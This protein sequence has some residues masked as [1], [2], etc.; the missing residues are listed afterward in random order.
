M[1]TYTLL[2]ISAL[3]FT[4]CGKS[5]DSAAPTPAPEA[6]K[7]EA[8]EAA[9]PEAAKPE[10]KPEAKKAEAAKPAA[11]PAAAAPAAAEGPKPG[12]LPAPPDVAAAPADATKTDS[13]LAFK[14]LNKG[15]GTEKPA[16][17]DTV[18]VHY[19]GWTTDGKM[20]DSSVKRGKPTEFPLNGVIKGW[21]EGV[22]LMTVGEKRRFWIPGNLAYGETPRRPGAPAGTLVFDVELLE[23]KKAPS[24]EEMKKLFGEFEAALK[25]AAESVC[26]CEDMG[27]AQPAMMKLRGI[28]PPGR[29]TPDQMQKLQPY[30]QKI[31]ECMQKIRK[32]ATAAPAPPAGKPAAPEA[33]AKPAAPAAKK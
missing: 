31:Q 6:A 28:R 8:K 32:P 29:P 9:K 14:V 4:G 2:L 33:P 10:A 13:G 21:T 20:F 1:K 26:K 7:P 23:I 12:D 5:G 3:A 25:D 24:P 16:A 18:K 17:E 19:T 27:C 30:M 22:G 15:T 11:K